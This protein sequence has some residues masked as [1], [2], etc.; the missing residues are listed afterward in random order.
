MGEQQDLFSA[1]SR[2]AVKRHPNP[3]HYEP[4]GPGLLDPEPSPRLT[5]CG[6]DARMRRHAITWE[7]WAGWEQSDRCEACE[8]AIAAGG[9]AVELSEMPA[10]PAGGE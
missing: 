2:P 4:N 1:A 9:V 5:A 3:L 8:V 10:R 7:V 6:R